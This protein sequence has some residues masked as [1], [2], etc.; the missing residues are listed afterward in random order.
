M[1]G[2]KCGE[3]RQ[4]FKRA[5]RR[6]KGARGS[7]SRGSLANSIW[8]KPRLG[9]PW[10]AY[11]RMTRRTRRAVHS[12]RSKRLPLAASAL[13]FR[14]GLRAHLRMPQRSHVIRIAPD[15]TREALKVSMRV[16]PRSVSSLQK[17]IDDVVH[18]WSRAQARNTFTLTQSGRP[19]RVTRRRMSNR[20]GKIARSTSAGEK[21]VGPISG[22]AFIGGDLSKRECSPRQHWNGRD[23]KGADGVL[24]RER[25]RMPERANSGEAQIDRGKASRV[26][27]SV[28]RFTRRAREM[29][30]AES[31]LHSN[32]R[33]NGIDE[34]TGASD[35]E[36]DEMTV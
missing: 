13:A 16:C 32:Q 12:V 22:E 35:A 7:Q 20:G 10:P 17:S 14:R 34:A 36:L 28:L 26:M 3:A 30:L 5:S 24:S 6:H 23:R 33:T 27:G 25:A 29:I 9:D 8:R 4:G 1:V 19:R 11:E 31:K 2:L 18:E 15:I 21:S